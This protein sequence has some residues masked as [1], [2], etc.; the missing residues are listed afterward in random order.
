MKNKGYQPTEH[1]IQTAIIGWLQYHKWMV[2]R[3][4]SG[5]IATGVGKYRRMI[6]LG[7]PGLPDIFAVKDG[8][9]AGIEVKKPGNKATDLQ[10]MM[11]KDLEDHGAWTLVAY[12]VDDVE[13]K[14][15]VI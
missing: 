11:L 3:N 7:T 14:F 12:S 10:K 9:L 6:K 2:W 8:I 1:E 4:N 13:K 15:K 5:M